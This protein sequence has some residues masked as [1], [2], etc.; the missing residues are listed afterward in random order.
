MAGLL[1]GHEA[2]AG[3]GFGHLAKAPGYA[4][5]ARVYS[6]NPGSDGLIHLPRER[7][8]SLALR[9]GDHPMAVKTVLPKESL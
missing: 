9:P 5:I 4:R 3:Y 8:T 7:G 2:P 1:R 6:S